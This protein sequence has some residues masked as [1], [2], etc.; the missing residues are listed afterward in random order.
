MISSPAGGVAPPPVTEGAGRIPVY[1]S[2]FRLEP[3]DLF[4]G[5]PV[6]FQ[7][8]LCPLH[9]LVLDRVLFAVRCKKLVVRVH[10]ILHLAPFPA[11][12]GD[13]I[14]EERFESEAVFPWPSFRSVP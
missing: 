7:I 14:N 4:L 10:R 1:F 3:V 5:S 2:R 6:I 8:C 9:V 12:W 11:Q 13:A